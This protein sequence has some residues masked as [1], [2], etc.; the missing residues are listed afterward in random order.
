MSAHPARPKGSA[1]NP[2]AAGA[3]VGTDW[4]ERNLG[5]PGLRVV[6]ATWYLPTAGRE[7]IDDYRKRHVPGAVF[8]DIDVITDPD[9]AL[10]H[11]LPGEADFSA[12]MSR[13]GIAR[14]SRVVVYDNNGMQTSPRVWW[15][16][17]AFGHRRVSVLD[18]GMRKWLAEGRPVS[19]DTPAPAPTSYAAWLDPALVRAIEEVPADPADRT[20]Q[21]LDARP[22]GRF[23]GV[24]PEPRPNCRPGRIP[25]S[26][27]LPSATL[28]DPGAGTFLTGAALEARFADSGLDLGAPVVASCG[29]GVT[30]CVLALGLHLLGKEDVAVYDG[31]WTEWGGGDRP[32]E[33]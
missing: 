32:V 20:E 23:A 22:A 16:L 33:T 25:G 13:L 10:P 31:S 14:D 19:T 29:S 8:W 24:D 17:R 2:P 1:V 28:V 21:V 27:N 5:E 12:H 7:G 3:L 11:M 26:L 9:S 4:L 6:E 18:G 30:A 15:T